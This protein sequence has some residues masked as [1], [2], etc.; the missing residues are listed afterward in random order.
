MTGIRWMGGVRHLKSDVVVIQ[1]QIICKYIWIFFIF[2]DIDG[3]TTAE[4]V[5]DKKYTYYCSATSIL[6]KYT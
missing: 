1:G 5:R 6:V 3:T 4:V 2:I